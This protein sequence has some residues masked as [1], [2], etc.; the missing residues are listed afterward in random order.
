MNF[1]ALSLSA[2]GGYVLTSTLLFI[3]SLTV[4]GV[5]L[6]REW[7][8]MTIVITIIFAVAAIFTHVVSVKSDRILNRVDIDKVIFSEEEIDFISSLPAS[9]QLITLK[10]IE[11][12]PDD[13]SI[14]VYNFSP[15]GDMLYSNYTGTLK[16]C[17]W[18][19]QKLD[20]SEILGQEP[21][22]FWSIELEKG[23]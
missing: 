19:P 4:E 20:A 22:W 6:T 12:Q 21:G 14:A 8:Q 13:N 15:I 9:A 16:V 5:T 10:R 17:N 1:K 11:P 2:L 23:V 3:L 18:R 7:W